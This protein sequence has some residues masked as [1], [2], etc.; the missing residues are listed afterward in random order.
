MVHT[1]YIL[2]NK[3]TIEGISSRSR[4]NY[5]RV[6]F[7]SENPSNYGIATIREGENLWN[8]GWK[9]NWK[10]IMGS[11]WWF[12]FGDGM[13]YP[14]NPIIHN[15]LIEEAKIQSQPQDDNRTSSMIQQSQQ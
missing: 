14:Y 4:T 15:R 9:Q 2:Q 5:V 13:I 1:I 12:W 10:N 6:Q 8:L 3:T 11:K 7:D